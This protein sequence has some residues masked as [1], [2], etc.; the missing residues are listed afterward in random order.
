MNLIEISYSHHIDKFR[1]ARE[2]GLEGRVIEK[3]PRFGKKRTSMM[4]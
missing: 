3:I 1:E 2:K 4:A